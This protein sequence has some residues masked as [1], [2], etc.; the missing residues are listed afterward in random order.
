MRGI[1]VGKKD[2]ATT[3]GATRQMVQALLKPAHQFLLMIILILFVFLW[4]LSIFTIQ[5]VT[6]MSSV[7]E[8]VMPTIVKTMLI[9]LLTQAN[10]ST[11]TPAV[12][13]PVTMS[14]R[15][16]VMPRMM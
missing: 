6:M 3:T 15:G 11:M 1:S 7:T 14:D 9:Q 5:I 13:S 10:T 4:S 2:W 16:N 12:T 8:L